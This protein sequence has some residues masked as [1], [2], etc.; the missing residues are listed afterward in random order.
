MPPTPTLAVAGAIDAPVT[1]GGSA[2][3]RQRLAPPSTDPILPSDTPGRPQRLRRAATDSHATPPVGPPAVSCKAEPA[4]PPART[5][6][7]TPAAAP[8]PAAAAAI[9]PPAAVPGPAPA[10]APAPAAPLAWANPFLRHLDGWEAD[11]SQTMQH[12]ADA[13]KLASI[14]ASRKGQDMYLHQPPVPWIGKILT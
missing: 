4:P 8:S 12:E 13:E 5:A 1:A 11:V 6:T 9:A 3:K 7:Q 10:P 14:K 2:R